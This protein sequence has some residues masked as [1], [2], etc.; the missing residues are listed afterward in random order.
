MFV[1]RFC[2]PP[3]QLATLAKFLLALATVLLTFPALAQ[4][5]TGT[6]NGVVRDPSGAN[7][8]SA[9]ITA[10]SRETGLTR[11]ATTHLMAHSAL[12]IFRLVVTP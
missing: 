10:T 3:T 1:H 5:T 4:Y 8:A 11:S 12:P 6:I 9:V 2:T 7:V